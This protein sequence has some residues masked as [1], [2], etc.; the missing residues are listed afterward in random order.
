MPWLCRDC[1][2]YFSV[3]TNWLMHASN[4][5]Y[6]NWARAIILLQPSTNTITSVA[7]A[8]E[9]GVSQKT[10]WHLKRRIQRQWNHNDTPTL[11]KHLTSTQKERETP[12][13]ASPILT[14]IFTA[15]PPREAEISAHNYAQDLRVALTKELGTYDSACEFLQTSY[16]TAAMKDACRMIFSRLRDGDASRQ[17]S[18]YRF[19]SLF[20]GGKTHTLI[21]LAAIAKYPDAPHTLPEDLAPLP[22][23]LSARDVNLVCFSGDDA[24]ARDGVMLTPDGSVRARS[25]LAAI[26]YEIGGKAAYERYREHDATLLP[27][28]GVEIESIIG[29]KP[30]LILLDEMAQ[31]I[32]TMEN[33]AEE[34]KLPAILSNIA[35]AAQNCPRAVMVI[36]SPEPFKDAFGAANAKLWSALQSLDSV[37]SRIS[38]E[39]TPTQSSDHAAILR[40]RL[41]KSCD[42]TARAAAADAYAAIA[43]RLRPSDNG[44]RKRF[45]DAYPFH[46]DTIRIIQE[47]LASN[48]NFQRVRGT[49]HLLSLVIDANAET[50]DAL[51]HPYHISAR[52][53]KVRDALINR[54]QKHELDAAIEADI[55]SDQSTRARLA[56]PLA[57]KTLNVT[58]LVSLARTA[59]Q[60][61]NDQEIVDAIISPFTPDDSLIRQAISSVRDNALYTSET[62]PNSLRFTEDPNIRREVINRRDKFTND[63]ILSDAIKEMVINTFAKSGDANPLTASIY[64]IDM[65]DDPNAAHLAIINSEYMHA[66]SK[67]LKDDLARMYLQSDKAGGKEPRQNKNHIIFLIAKEPNSG[68]LRNAVLQFKAAQDVKKNPGVKLEPHQRAILADIY[69]Q[70]EKDAYQCVQ[71]IW[72]EMFYPSTENRHWDDL[73]L[74]HDTLT[75]KT[76]K[77]GY[78]QAAVMDMLVFRGK[79]PDPHALAFN[80]T[81][82]ARHLSAKEND[83]V[84]L[85]DLRQKFAGGPGERMIISPQHWESLI[86]AAIA[87]HFIEMAFPDGS[88]IDDPR[89][90][91]G[92][93]SPECKVWLAGA[94]PAPAP[95]P[96][97]PTTPEPP[98]ITHLPPTTPLF[99]RGESM[100]GRLAAA[101]LQKHMSANNVTAN[102]L[103]E[104]KIHGIG[105]DLLEFIASIDAHPN[106]RFTYQFENAAQNVM[107]DITRRRLAEWAP[108]Q[109][110]IKTLARLHRSTSGDRESA[111][112]E[113]AASEVGAAAIADC[114]QKIGNDHEVT[115]EARF[116]PEEMANE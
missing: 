53:P 23:D 92:G 38:H 22:A 41:F 60:G 30:T 89:A 100:P 88:T 21:T 13:M 95:I 4:I 116:A 113:F 86:D 71:S 35:R 47:R 67:N 110:A 12:I 70:A 104:L 5:S 107:L 98:V 9:L 1:R 73:Q 59:N 85:K 29:N 91:L 79:T 76:N 16:N 37:F 83:G 40:R 115:L 39:M 19:H 20:G 75:H 45:Y 52:D 108:A 57:E 69:A 66:E 68:Q 93:Y 101:E 74:R 43:Q 112:A 77:A 14:P 6:E 106:V 90:G 102:R 96:P 44:A 36:T 82:W 49:L 31:W 78:G 28:G 42:E 114:L 34:D 3:K 65:P 26:A 72:T 84:A 109:Q 80:G 10:A 62:D 99:Y 15:C 97:K 105:I 64:P 2:Y 61:L 51:L 32:A 87:N 25:P 54:V 8:K 17:P 33:D 7:L 56:S 63:Q 24:N 111:T 58:L 11:I 48:N 94:K 81:I 50:T 103:A 18:I 55:T 46:P 27:T